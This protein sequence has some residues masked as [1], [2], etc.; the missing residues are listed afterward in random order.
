[1]KRIML[2]MAMLIS[3]SS[4]AKDTLTIGVKQS[5][6]FAYTYVDGEWDGIAIEL[7]REYLHDYNMSY[8]LVEYKSSTYD[9]I[10][11]SVAN[12]DIDIFAGDITITNDRLM[13]VDFSQPYYVTNTLIATLKTDEPSSISGLFTVS[14]VESMFMLLIFILVSGLI[15]WLVEKNHNDGFDKGLMGIFDGSYFV[16]ATM[17][18]VGYGDVAAK[19]KV[20]KVLSFVLMW[21]SL[22]IVGYMYGNITTALTIAELEDG[23]ENISEL[24]KMK[25]GTINGTTSST[26]LTDNDIKYINYD[27]AEEGFDAMIDGELDA[28]VY[29]KPILQYLAAKDRYSDVALSQTE[30]MEQ[31]YGFVFKKNSYFEDDLNRSILKTIRGEQWEGIMN[32]YNLE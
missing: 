32:K 27:S 9:E 23:I 25:V 7:I 4:I 19:T 31:T 18:T 1:M 2:M 8:R 11:D 10:I 30:F 17:T 6:P 20:G 13:E 12:G 14:F 21:V 16:S 26:F 22:G 24:N 28:F 3:L 15:M 29:D 5:E